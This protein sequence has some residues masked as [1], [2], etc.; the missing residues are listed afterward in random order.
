MSLSNYAFLIKA[1]G[2]PASGQAMT[3]PGDGFTTHIFA[4]SD[5]NTLINVANTLIED[6]I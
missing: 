5:I 6:G 4:A 1:D 2:Y 3:L